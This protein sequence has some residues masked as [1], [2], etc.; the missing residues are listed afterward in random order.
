MSIPALSKASLLLVIVL[1]V[2]GASPAGTG[3]GLKSTTFSAILGVMRSAVR[4]EK[5]VRFW[6]RPV[7]L[8]R[9][10]TAVASL[11]FYLG[12]LIVGTYLLELTETSRFDQNFFEAAS[13]LGTVG[14]STGITASLTA[15]G[16]LIVI[17]LMYCGRLGPLTLGMALFLQRQEEDK[18]RDNDLA[19]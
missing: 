6:G 15:M 12:A 2:I 7:P 8:E 16:K 11:G 19:V 4:G 1:M 17:G 10:W 13:A 5:E 18:D 9:V 14:L 3:G